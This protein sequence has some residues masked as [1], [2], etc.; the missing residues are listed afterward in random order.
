MQMFDG[1]EFYL[2]LC[3]R[4]PVLYAENQFV[5]SISS[6][7]FPTWLFH[8]MNFELLFFKTKLNLKLIQ[9]TIII[10]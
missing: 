7:F 10:I 3:G 4:V 6:F 5:E 9:I 8:Q 1:N 2:D